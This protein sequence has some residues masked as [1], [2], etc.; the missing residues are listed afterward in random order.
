[1]RLEAYVPKANRLTSIITSHA[2]CEF[3]TEHSYTTRQHSDLNPPPQKKSIIIISSSM[4]NNEWTHV[5]SWF[6]EAHLVTPVRMNSKY[7]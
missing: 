5:L 7:Q 6:Y 4:N 1:M 2:V 3:L